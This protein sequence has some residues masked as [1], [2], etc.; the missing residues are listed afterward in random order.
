MKTWVISYS[1]LGD[2]ELFDE[3]KTIEGRNALDALKRHFGVEFKRLTGD[4]G[5][6][7]EVILIKGYY[8]DNNIYCEGRCNRLCYSRV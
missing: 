3:Y 1:A 7:A 8:K 2:N 4:S 6:Y 5:R